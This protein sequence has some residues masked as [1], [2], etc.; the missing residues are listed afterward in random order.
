MPGLTTEQQT[1]LGA[2]FTVAEV[3]TAIGGL[4]TRRATHG[5]VSE[6][7]KGAVGQLLVSSAWK[8]CTL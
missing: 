7:L 8:T 4:A 3:K 5:V 1:K 6:V 2:D